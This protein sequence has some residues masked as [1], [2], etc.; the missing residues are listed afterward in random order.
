MEFSDSRL[1]ESNRRMCDREEG[2]CH[3]SSAPFWLSA[4]RGVDKACAGPVL[5]ESA[6]EEAVLAEGVAAGAWPP[7]LVCSPWCLSSGGGLRI[8]LGGGLSTERIY[9]GIKD[10]ANVSETISKQHS[11]FTGSLTYLQSIIKRDNFPIVC[12]E[13]P[14]HC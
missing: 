10:K 5:E 4:S 13:K 12:V 14:I 2:D 9:C 11:A 6:G 1:W 3:A 8:I 7:W